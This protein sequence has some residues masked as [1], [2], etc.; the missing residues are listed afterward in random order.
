MNAMSWKEQVLLW[1]GRL[2]RSV[3]G[4]P[5]PTHIQTGGLLCDFV[6]ENVPKVLPQP[7]SGT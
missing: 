2:L 5:P 7:S 3:V 1:Y 4:A 6:L